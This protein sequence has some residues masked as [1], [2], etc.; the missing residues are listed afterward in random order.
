MQDCWSFTCLPLFL[1]CLSSSLSSVT[2]H[3][4]YK[5]VY[6]N[7][8]FPC[9][10]RFALCLS[11]C[12]PLTYD[13]NG[14]KSR[15]NRHLLNVGSFKTGFLYALIFLGFSFFCYLGFLSWTFTIHRTAGEWEA[16]SLSP[17]YYFHALHRHRHL[18][19]SQAST[20]ASLPLHIA[21]SQ[22]RTRNFGFQVQVA[23]H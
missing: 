18:D 17:F 7:S 15:I 10:I 16:I 2:I 1:A 3:R 14:F 11:N 5:D 23:N 22:T 6:V 8:F 9:T 20:A 19:I 13:L 4:C 21:S 12:F